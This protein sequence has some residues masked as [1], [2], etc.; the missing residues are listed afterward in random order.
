VI[1]DDRIN[2]T[3]EDSG[4]KILV[5]FAAL[6]GGAQ[7]SYLIRHL[8]EQTQ[9]RTVTVNRFESSLVISDE[10]EK[11]ITIRLDRDDERRR[12]LAS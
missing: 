9:V 6:H 3:G 12:L 11:E 4:I 7:H 10:L 1:C 2:A 5:Q 8:P